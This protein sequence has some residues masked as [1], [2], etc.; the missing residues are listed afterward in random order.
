[1][2][3]I[4]ITTKKFSILILISFVVGLATGILSYHLLGPKIPELRN[5]IQNESIY[6]VEQECKEEIVEE[7][8]VDECPIKVDVSGALVD[9]GVYCFQKGDTVID[10]VKKAGGFVDEVGIKFISRKLNLAGL[11]YGSQKLYFPYAEDLICTLQDFN[12]YTKEVEGLFDDNSNQ[13][14]SQDS[15][16]SQNDTSDEDV[17]DTGNDDSENSD[18]ININNSSKE[19]LMQ[20][21]GVGESTAQKIIEARP[22]TVIEDIL[23]VSGIGDTT[24]NNIKD[25][26]CL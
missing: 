7:E 18:C 12:P 6:I 2:K 4:Q 22:F 1:M 5:R 17:S 14:D 9:P 21:N 13:G 19:E 3:D 11:L 10:A 16:D 25:N 26:I 15:I 8:K 20:L 24:F 23:N